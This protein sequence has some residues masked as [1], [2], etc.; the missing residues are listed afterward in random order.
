MTATALIYK[1]HSLPPEMQTE[2]E[3]YIDFL[4]AKYVQLQPTTPKKRKA[5]FLK[6]TFV[7]HED[8]NAPLEDF[9]EYME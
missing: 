8:F 7:M 5:G 6:G 1:I 2:I 3:H 9:K 4:L